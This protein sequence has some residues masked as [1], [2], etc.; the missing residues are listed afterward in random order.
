MKWSNERY[1]G[2]RFGNRLP[3]PVVSHSRPFIF[4]VKTDATEPFTGTALSNRGF[5]LEYKQIPCS[6]SALDSVSFA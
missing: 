4:R 1:C 6:L 5:N 2:H 3:G